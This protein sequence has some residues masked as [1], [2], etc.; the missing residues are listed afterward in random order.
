M[1]EQLK[2]IAFLVPKPGI[3]DE[4]F[5]T[6]WREIHGPLVAG[7]PGYSEWRQRY[8]QNHVLDR[9]PVGSPFEFAGVAEFWL[10]GNSPNEDEF[11]STTIYRDRI[12]VDEMNFIDMER[13]VSMA[14]LEEVVMAGRGDVKLVILSCRAPGLE[15]VDFRSRFA[16]E[17]AGVA[18][19]DQDVHRRVR[20]WTV[21]HVIDGSFRLPGARPSLALPVDC[22]EEIWFDSVIEREAAFD[23]A[24]Y[25][26][27]SRSVAERL[28]SGNHRSSFLAEE[29]V[30]FERGRPTETGRAFACGRRTA[31]ATSWN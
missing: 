12:H 21:N 26:R 9:G 11:S 3:A 6:Y 1:P 22:I 23:S 13:T 8:V 4:A 30:F 5:R 19:G 18:L 10:P 17:Y 14:A 16:S 27:G 2:K 25:A 31:P 24:G 28:F 7:S 15:Q 29:L 20:G